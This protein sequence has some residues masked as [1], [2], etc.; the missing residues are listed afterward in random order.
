MLNRLALY[1]KIDIIWK[2]DD[3]HIKVSTPVLSNWW[4]RSFLIYWNNQDHQL[5]LKVICSKELKNLLFSFNMNNNSDSKMSTKRASKKLSMPKFTRQFSSTDFVKKLSPDINFGKKMKPEIGKKFWTS[6]G[7]M[8][9]TIYEGKLI[10]IL[11]CALRIFY[12]YH[13]LIFHDICLVM[14]WVFRQ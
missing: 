10:N 12:L 14:L 7:R 11:K 6:I 13:Y 3:H 5:A 8:W 9:A 4:R 1:F 2:N